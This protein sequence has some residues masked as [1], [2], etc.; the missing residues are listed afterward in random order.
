MALDESESDTNRAM[1]QLAIQR[2]MLLL[3]QLKEDPVLQQAIPIFERVLAQTNLMACPVH[4][5]QVLPGAPPE[6]AYS[7]SQTVPG[8]QGEENVPVL[9]DPFGE[10]SLWFKDFLGFDFLDT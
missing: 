1:C 5:S 6:G 8:Q 9:Q 10:Y 2:S 4:R 3:G 7:L